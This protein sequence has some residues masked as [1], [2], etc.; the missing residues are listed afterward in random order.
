M[1]QIERKRSFQKSSKKFSGGC[2]SFV[3][4]YGFHNDDINIINAFSDA[5]VEVRCGYTTL[6]E[7]LEGHLPYGTERVKK[8]FQF[9]YFITGKICIAQEKYVI[10]K[11]VSSNNIIKAGLNSII[12]CLG[13]SVAMIR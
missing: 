7:P 12:F 6:Q 9:F 5:A 2:L 11:R 4:H 13:K 8:S 3:R 1:I 10:I